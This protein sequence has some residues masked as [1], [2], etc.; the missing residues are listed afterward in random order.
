MENTENLLDM[1][2]STIEVLLDDIKNYKPL[3]ESQL[4]KIESL[5]NEEKITIIKMYN[6]VLTYLVEVIDKY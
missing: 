6:V 3:S 1:K 5:T 2:R 4:E